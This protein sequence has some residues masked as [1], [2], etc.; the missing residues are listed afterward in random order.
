MLLLKDEEVKRIIS[1][2]EAISIVEKAF[3]YYSNNKAVVP[4]RTQIKM[5]KKNQ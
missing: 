4:N 1:M 2:K 3:K 5:S